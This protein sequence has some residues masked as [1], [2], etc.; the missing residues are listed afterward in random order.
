[1]NKRVQ[2]SKKD[3]FAFIIIVLLMVGGLVYGFSIVEVGTVDGPK[4]DNSGMMTDECKKI[5]L[6]K[7][8]EEAVKN[9]C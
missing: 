1:M 4:V 8:E 2:Q 6:E 3:I 9:G 5:W 7:G